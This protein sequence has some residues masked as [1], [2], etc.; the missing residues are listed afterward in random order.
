MSR[1]LF[2]TT[3]LITTFLI[4]TF[5]INAERA[6]GDLDSLVDDEDDVAVA[7]VTTAELR[8]GALLA[9]ERRRESRACFVAEGMPRGRTT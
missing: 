6:E 8:V 2:D 9:H 3:S 1:L 4:D 7:A 5:L